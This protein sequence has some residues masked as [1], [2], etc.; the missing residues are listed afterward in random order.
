[1]L[2]EE[3]VDLVCRTDHRRRSLPEGAACSVCGINWPLVLFLRRS[4]IWCYQCQAV[5][6][7]RARI[8]LH[9][10]GGQGSELIVPIPLN[11]HIVLT[12]LQWATWRGLH[13]P[14]SPE[15]VAADAAM[16][17]MVGIAYLIEMDR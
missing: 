9:H 8:E 5:S 6:R 3:M 7:G 4:T 17:V 1:M 12:H 10:V 11:V 13:A 2:T 14:G 15:A 16:L